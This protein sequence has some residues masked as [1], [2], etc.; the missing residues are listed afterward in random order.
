VGRNRS[1]IPALGCK[2]LTPLYDSLIGFF[3]PEGS[4]KKRLIEQSG[5]TR[6]VSRVLDVG[7]GTATLALIIKRTDPNIGVFGLDIDP[8][9]LRIAKRKCME[10]D[11]FLIRADASRLP[12]SDNAFDVVFSSLLLHHLTLENKRRAILEVFR[13]LRPGGEFHIADFGKPHN[14]YT[15]LVSFLVRRFE[16]ISDNIKGLLPELLC[17]SGFVDVRETARYTTVFGTLSLYRAKKTA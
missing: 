17:N 12:Y 13:V 6:G 4:F 14:L 11:I 2:S 8:D 1:Y 9:I 16:E 10:T 5:I 3:L 7:C 15:H